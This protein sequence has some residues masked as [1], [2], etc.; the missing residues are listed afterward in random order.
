MCRVAIVKV[1]ALFQ[2]RNQPCFD[3]DPFLLERALRGI[4]MK[5]QPLRNPKIQDSR[6]AKTWQTSTG[7]PS[8]NFYITF[9]DN[10]YQGTCDSFLSVF[11]WNLKRLV[12]L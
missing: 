8:D 2:P 12:I 1:I 5:R 3:D 7:L 11:A 4:W 9:I 6:E 10:R